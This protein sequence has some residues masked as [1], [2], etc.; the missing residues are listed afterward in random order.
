MTQTKL[1][2][3]IEKEGKWYTVTCREL[4]VAS[5][6][7]SVAEARANLAEALELFFECANADELRR[8]L[9]EE[10]RGGLLKNVAGLLRGEYVIEWRLDA[11]VRTQKL[12]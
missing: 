3:V 10:A 2:G 12:H 7:E 11:D 8:R 4:N 5:Q 9:N 6:G 1:T